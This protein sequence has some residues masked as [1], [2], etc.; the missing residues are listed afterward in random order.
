ML[1]N[2]NLTYNF[3]L[4]EVNKK[5]ENLYS[6]FKLMLLKRDDTSKAALT[7]TLEK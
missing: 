7:K 6:K 3:I 2:L 4:Q 1:Y 5:I